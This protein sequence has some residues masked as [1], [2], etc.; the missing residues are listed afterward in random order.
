MY[1]T[2]MLQL[3]VSDHVEVSNFICQH[4][5]RS[6]AFNKDGKNTVL[7]SVQIRNYIGPVITEQINFF[8]IL[9]VVSFNKLADLFY[10]LFDTLCGGTQ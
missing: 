8:E 2:K 7:S 10:F 1:T 4:F 9:S 3:K 5:V 6:A